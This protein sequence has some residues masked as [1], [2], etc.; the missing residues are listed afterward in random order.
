M[1]RVVAA[2]L[3]REVSGELHYEASKD[4]EPTVWNKDELAVS[5]VGMQD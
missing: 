2:L 4:D 1:E 5:S 3:H